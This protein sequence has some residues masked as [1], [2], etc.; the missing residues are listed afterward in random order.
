MVKELNSLQ[1][2]MFTKE[3]TCTV[4]RMGMDSTIGKMDHSTKAI[5]EMVSDMAMEFGKEGAELLTGIKDSMLTIKNRDMGYSAGQMATSTR[6]IT[7][8]ISEMGLV[9]CSG[10]MVAII[11]ANG[12]MVSNKVREKFSNPD[13]D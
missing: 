2:E 10:T 8:K 3:N 1:M 7:K 5:L 12:K 11:K 9:Q 6:E 4:N 13:K